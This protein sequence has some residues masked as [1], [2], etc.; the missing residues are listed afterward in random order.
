MEELAPVDMK[1]LRPE[2]APNSVSAPVALTVSPAAAKTS[3]ELPLTVKLA[4]CADEKM[5]LALVNVAEETP[6]ATDTAPA[7]LYVPLTVSP[8]KETFPIWLM[9]AIA[10]GLP[11]AAVNCKTKV[12][13]LTVVIDTL[14]VALSK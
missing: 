8:E 11:A 2:A 14:I 3:A 1:L 9:A 6:D 10:E 7:A 12:A 4:F 5:T 13:P